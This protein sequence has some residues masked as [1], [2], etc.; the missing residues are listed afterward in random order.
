V[1]GLLL[2]AAYLTV[3]Q[4]QLLLAVPMKGLGACLAMALYQYH[5]N[6]FPSYTVTD[7]RFTC[8]RAP[9]FTPKQHDPHGVRHVRNPHLFADTSSFKL[10]FRVNWLALSRIPR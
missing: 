2:A 7:Q 4:A 1:A 6:D 8:L 10:D 5:P 9:A 3:S